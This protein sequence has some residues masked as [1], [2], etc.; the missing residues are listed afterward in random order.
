MLAVRKTNNRRSR[1]RLNT[2][3]ECWYRPTGNPT[4]RKTR[5]CDLS[6]SGA[7]IYTP[8]PVREGNTIHLTLR[9]GQ[10]RYL[11]LS[12]RAV[13]QR[14]CPCGALLGVEFEQ[15]KSASVGKWLAGQRAM[16]LTE[17]GAQEPDTLTTPRPEPA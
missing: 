16:K 8:D 12:A 2:Q 13:W 15:A 9:L 7:G 1:L 4:F 5:L 17:M 10:G 6:E 3:M 14:P 11:S